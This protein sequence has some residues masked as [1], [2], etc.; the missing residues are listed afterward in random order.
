MT[1]RAGRPWLLVDVD[2]VLNVSPTP[3]MLLSGWQPHDVLGPLDVR[4]YRLVVNPEH[5]E[6][7][8]SLSDVYRL[9]WATTWWRVADERIAPLIGLPP[10]GHAVP[11]P[12]AFSGVDLGCCP[13]T[14]HVRRWVDGASVAWIDDDIDDRDHEALTGQA[15]HKRDMVRVGQPCAAALALPVDPAVG[16]TWSHIERLRAWAEEQR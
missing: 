11:L 16:L 8:M 4:T 12:G 14:P 9:A 7:L 5:G 3:E 1:P 2:G 13:K 10:L 6:W 15:R